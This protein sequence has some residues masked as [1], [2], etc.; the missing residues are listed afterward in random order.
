M[1]GGILQKSFPKNFTKFTEK[2]LCYSLIL[3]LLK[4]F[5]P[6]GLQFYWRVTPVLVFQNKLFVDPLQNRC[7][8]IIHK[9]HRKTSLEVDIHRCSSKELF[10]KSLQI[11]R[12]IT[13]V[14]VFFNKVAGP[15]NCNFIK[16][17]LQHKFFPVKFAKFLRTRCFT[18][19]LQW[20]LLTVLGLDPAILLKKRHWQR[21]FFC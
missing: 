11:S 4:A 7:S 10:L 17:R 12:E 15:Q 3:I 19:H 20:L 21:C 1:L 18:E 8:W 2:Y 14:R 9:I 16:N 13:R 5:K 6:S